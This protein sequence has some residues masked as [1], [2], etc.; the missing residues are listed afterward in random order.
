MT[1]R[2]YNR[3][4]VR[5]SEN[6]LISL[7]LS[8]LE[9]YSVKKKDIKE[10]GRPKSRIEVYGSLFGHEILM[11]N[12]EILYQVEMAHTDTTAEQRRSS[13]DENK[14][15]ISLKADVITSFWPHLIY[16]GDFHSHPFKTTQE[17]RKDKKYFMSEDDREWLNNNFWKQK[18]YRVGLI[19]HAARHQ[20]ALHRG[21]LGPGRAFFQFCG[22]FGQHHGQPV[23]IHDHGRAD[24]V[25]EI[26]SR[27]EP[28]IKVAD[29]IDRPNGLTDGVSGRDRFLH[30]LIGNLDVQFPAQVIP[31]F[32]QDVHHVV[33]GACRI[34]FNGQGNIQM[35]TEG[36][37]HPPDIGQPLHRVAGVRKNHA[38]QILNPA[39]E[40]LLQNSAHHGAAVRLQVGIG[41]A[42]MLFRAEKPQGMGAR[43]HDDL[44]GR[45][46]TGVSDDFLPRRFFQL[47]GIIGRVRD[48]EAIFLQM[49]HYFPPVYFPA[50]RSFSIS[51]FSSSV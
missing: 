1:P 30:S 34:E 48:R 41:Q 50:L 20:D 27:H 43:G 44:L 13:V 31:E 8:S 39:G 9:A 21:R 15:A 32:L 33:S 35:K 47:S 49:V 12:R 42:D 10:K 17:V 28:G 37:V 14:E 19:A 2:I 3:Y 4:V 45:V 5:I 23:P 29:V 22:C 11:K 7:V 6:A 25:V 16:L 46:G 18:G 36:D 38:I 40:T 26:L 24:N 51:C